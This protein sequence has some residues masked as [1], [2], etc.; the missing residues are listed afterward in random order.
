MN[1]KETIISL[2]SSVKRDGMENLLKFL[3][4]SSFYT[5]PASCQEHNSYDGGLAD[6]SLNVYQVLMNYKRINSDLDKLEDSIKIIGLLHD[7]SYVG[8]FQKITKNVTVKG[9]AGKNVVREDGRLLFTEKQVYDPYYEAQLPYPH[10]QLSTMLVK[11]YIKLSKLEDLSIQWQHGEKDLP[12]HL[13]PLVRRAQKMNPLILY[14]N[15]ADIEANIRY[16]HKQEKT[17]E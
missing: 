8:T 9:S 11:Q 17:N 7:I 2:L 12:P 10:G 3:E 5:D 16:P 4:E 1:T 14:T 13:Y 6:H 15:L